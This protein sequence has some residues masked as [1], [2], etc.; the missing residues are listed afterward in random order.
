MTHKGSST[1]HPSSSAHPAAP[2]GGGS[3]SPEGQH[4]PAAS[5]PLKVA[6]AD[7]LS[8]ATTK[9]KAKAG[10]PVP[11]RDKV[12]RTA[13]NAGNE[14]A[15]AEKEDQPTK[16]G[17]VMRHPQVRWVDLLNELR[18]QSDGVHAKPLAEASVEPEGD[19]V[20][21]TVDTALEAAAEVI[22]RAVLAV[23]GINPNDDEVKKRHAAI[24]E[25]V[26]ANASRPAYNAYLD[27][28][29]ARIEA[30]GDEELVELIP[31]I[32]GALAGIDAAVAGSPGPKASK[33]PLE[34]QAATLAIH[35]AL[36]DLLRASG[37]RATK[38]RL[39]FLR[40]ILAPRRS[41]DTRANGTNNGGDG[42]GGSGGDGGD[43]S[44]G[45][46]GKS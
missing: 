1:E 25:T 5:S 20:E 32:D 43:G 44:G 28:L 23:D 21:S 35:L 26:P 45:S 29:K 19:A 8:Q 7:Y 46:G 16:L 4:A 30:S 33:T 3:E 31:L 27:G 36:S 34:D 40:Q 10:H 22:G 6:A 41:T 37:L 39:G 9:L 12:H 24:L 38:P 15:K 2:H 42:S 17:F 11:K 13:V 18:R 14:V